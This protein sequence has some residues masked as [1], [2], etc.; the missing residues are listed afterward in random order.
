MSKIDID[1]EVFITIFDFEL[2]DKFDK[3]L[4][5]SYGQKNYIKEKH[6]YDLICM[7]FKPPTIFFIFGSDTICQNLKCPMIVYKKQRL[8]PADNTLDLRDI[9]STL[10]VIYQAT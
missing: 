1:V 2:L 3:L 8:Q 5:T 10:D 9:K 7:S 4:E 6:S